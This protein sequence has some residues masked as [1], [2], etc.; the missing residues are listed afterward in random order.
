M[1]LPSL[2]TDPHRQVVTLLGLVLALV[3]ANL[4][5]VAAHDDGD[6]VRS[7]RRVA[8]GDVVSPGG[9]PSGG[10]TAG[11]ATT[12]VDPETGEP[13]V[14]DPMAP[15]PA[16]VDAA[17]ATAGGE[18]G[19]DTAP[20]AAPAGGG[21][22]GGGA[23]ALTAS[24]TGVTESVVRLGVLLFDIGG[25]SRV[26]FSFP[27]VDPSEQREA[28][29]AYIDEVNAGGGINGR[30]L[31]PHYVTYDAVSQDSMRA[32]CLQQTRDNKVFAVVDLG[33]MN[34]PPILCV[35]KEN[36]TPFLSFSNYGMPDDWYSASNGYLFTLTQRGTRIL[37]NFAN[38]LHRFGE[39]R[40]KRIGILADDD[41]SY[42]ST[43]DAGL[44]KQLQALGYEVAARYDLAADTGTGATQIPIAVNQ[45]RNARVDA[46]LLATNSL[47]ATQFVQQG[48]SQGFRPGYYTSDWWG[49]YSDTYAQNMPGAYDGAIAITTTRN[50]EVRAGTPEAREDADCRETWEQA[51][52]KKLDRSTIAYN[53]TLRACAL[54]RLVARGAAAAGADLTRDRFS[55]GMQGL[56]EV[57]LP[58]FHGGSFAQGKFDAADFVRPLRWRA[59]CTCHVPAGE[60]RRAEH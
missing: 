8:S 31:E 37:R 26:G 10:S 41:A 22:G 20:G 46:V 18:G 44:V 56:G 33:G 40:G 4:V 60:P 28:W 16:E 29:Q 52:G 14:V 3:V 19:G 9:R 1:K 15:P 48:E 45:F 24:D 42:R 23:A 53:S 13:I 34:G 57:P 25:A 11:T 49:G 32:S 5:V 47:Y 35:T 39:L 51:T 43:V 36:R 6:G 12:A 58:T 17:S 21:G 55:A 59:D 50:G 30:Q 38:E 2:P 7:D 27:G 54:T